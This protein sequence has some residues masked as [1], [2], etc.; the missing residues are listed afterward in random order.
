MGG[1]VGAGGRV[2]SGGAVG[3][4]GKVATGGAMGSGG[5]LGSGGSS[6]SGGSK[7]TGGATGQGGGGGT[8]GAGGRDGGGGQGGQAIDG[9]DIC[10]Q[11]V[12]DYANAFVLAKQCAPGAAN[13]CQQLA[14]ST[15][16]QCPGCDQYVNDATTLTAI[17]TKWINQG[18]QVP[19]FCPAIACVLPGPSTCL[20][21]GT[22]ADS[23]GGGVC[24]VSA[25]TPT[26]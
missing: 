26:Q 3:A 10:S 25:I 13:Q 16:A 11:L 18:C 20:A 21:T 22:M 12:T 19:I 1:V 5:M 24:S 2:G 23:A 17:R 14:Q 15:L 6:A 4:G 8:A 7:G 9:G